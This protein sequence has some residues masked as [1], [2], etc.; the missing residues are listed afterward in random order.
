MKNKIKYAEEPLGKLDILRDFLPPPKELVFKEEGVK[1]TLTLNKSSVA[2]FKKAAR[3]HHTP[4]Q[5]MI[6]NLIDSYTA[7]APRDG[8]S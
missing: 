1:V 6:R 7:R 8:K 2:F 4:Y 3:K 5:K